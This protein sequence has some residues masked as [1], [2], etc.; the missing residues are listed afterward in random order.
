MSSKNEDFPTPVSPTRRMVH[1][2]CDSLLMTAC[3]SLAM[4]LEDTV[5]T[6]PLEMFQN[7]LDSWNTA[8]PVTSA[9]R[10]FIVCRGGSGGSVWGIIDGFIRIRG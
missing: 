7:L 5:R 6:Q 10:I 2:K 8:P 9:Q 3:L 1:G 4:P